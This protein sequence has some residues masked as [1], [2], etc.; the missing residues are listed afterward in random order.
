MNGNLEEVYNYKN[1]KRAWKWLNSNTDYKYKNYFRDIY[2]AYAI[3]IDDNLKD[4]SKRIERDK[5]TPTK[6]AKMFVPKNSYLTREFTLLAIEDQIIYQAFINV[7]AEFYNKKVKKRYDSI[8]FSNI[9][10]GK[11]SPYFYKDW[12]EH[13]IKFSRA[14][15]K[16]YKLGYNYIASFDLTAFYD[17]I[18]HKIL[19]HMLMDMGLEAELINR[20]VF[21]LSKWTSNHETYKGHGIPQGPLSSG[22][23]AEVILANIDKQY[24]KIQGK[25]D[26]KYFRY[27]DDIKILGK[28]TRTLK[29]M[30]ARLDYASKQI[31]LFP[32]GNKIDIH[33]ISSIDDEVKKISNINIEKIK[34]SMTNKDIEKEMKNLIKK[35]EIMDVSKFKI[36]LTCVKPNSKL[37]LKL[38]EILHIYPNLFINISMYFK[39]YNR[40]IPNKVFKEIMKEIQNKEVYQTVN[41]YLIDAIQDNL[42]TDNEKTLYRFAC[43]RWKQRK[44]SPL[45]PMYRN[46]LIGL[47]LKKDYFKYDEIKDILNKESDW[48][49]K[50]SIIKNIN[51]EY[52]GEPS[53]VELMRIMLQSDVAD[54]SIC[55]AHEIIKSNYKLGGP[56]KDFNHISQKIL[57]SGGIIDKAKSS[58]SVIQSKLEFICNGSTTKYKLPKRDWK[59]IF[60]SEH[61]EAENKIIRAYGYV[62]NDMSAFVNILDT[63]NDILLDRL[64]EH[65]G[66]IGLY[67]LGKIGSVLNPNCRFAKGYPKLYK[68][69]REIH[70]KRLES[71]LSH[72]KIKATGEYTTYI[73]Y[74]Y[75]NSARKTL[76]EGYKEF[77]EKW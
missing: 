56:Y 1:L 39:D 23:L 69:C 36:Y 62:Q 34:I 49:V 18:D 16:H 5:F 29:Y 9:Y 67:E 60:K 35:D 33:K 32:Q 37:S 11:T 41:A 59:K 38:L 47:L 30:I 53:F 76:Y 10:S 19:S 50:K 12:K 44:Q 65:D 4:L 40:I 20:L 73:K 21:Y 71:D 58:P 6:P 48:W 7:I 75:I 66:S 25:E 8:V 22:L 68:L 51:K 55:G 63:F 61:D 3:S 57:K 14:I 28:D 72:P 17:S 26:I 46:V 13:Y 54:I 70:D 45:N 42:S 15:K 77:L 74:S 27:A 52:I 24:E 2:T 31:G 43:Y 64:F